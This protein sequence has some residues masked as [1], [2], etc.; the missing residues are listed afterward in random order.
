MWSEKIWTV[1]D[2]ASQNNKVEKKNPHKTQLQVPKPDNTSVLNNTF[3]EC[4]F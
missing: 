1:R 4:A 2:K 3:S